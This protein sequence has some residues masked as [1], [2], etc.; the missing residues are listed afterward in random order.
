MKVLDQESPREVD[1]LVFEMWHFINVVVVSVVVAAV[2]VH[3][4]LLINLLLSYI[5]LLY[6][7]WPSNFFYLFSTK[8][9]KCIFV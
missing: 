6:T 2:V 4:S 5:Y 3:H 9:L 1:G 8:P 7:N